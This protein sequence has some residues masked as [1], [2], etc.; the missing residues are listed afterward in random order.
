MAVPFGANVGGTD[1]FLKAQ[2]ALRRALDR[3]GGELLG[4][5]VCAF[6]NSLGLLKEGEPHR[7]T[8]K[9]FWAREPYEQL[10]E[11]LQAA[12]APVV[13]LKEFEDS[14]RAYQERLMR[15]DKLLSPAQISKRNADEAREEAKQVRAMKRALLRMRPDRTRYT[16]QHPKPGH[17]GTDVWG[18]NTPTSPEPPPP[19]LGWADPPPSKRPGRPELQPWEKMPAISDQDKISIVVSSAGKVLAQTAE[20]RQKNLYALQVAR[21]VANNPRLH[22]GDLGI[23]SGMVSLP[24]G[25]PKDELGN[26]D[27][28]TPLSV[29]LQML[30]LFR[31]GKLRATT[32]EERKANR[33]RRREF[34]EMPG[35]R[36]I[37]DARQDSLAVQYGYAPTPPLPNPLPKAPP[38]A[39]AKEK[40][41]TPGSEMAKQVAEAEAR[42]VKNAA[43]RTPADPLL[44]AVEENSARAS[45]ALREAKQA[46]DSVHLAMSQL[47][48]EDSRAARRIRDNELKM[49]SAYEAQQSRRESTGEE[50]TLAEESWAAM[51]MTSEISTL[52]QERRS[53]RMKQQALQPDLDAAISVLLR[54]RQL[55]DINEEHKLLLA[56]INGEQNV[57]VSELRSRYGPAPPRKRLSLPHDAPWQDLA[58][59]SELESMQS[60]EDA[61][62]QEAWL[63][64]VA[65]HQLQVPF[66]EA[67]KPPLR[68][69]EDTRPWVEWVDRRLQVEEEVKDLK[70]QILQRQEQM[71]SDI[72]ELEEELQWLRLL[73][74]ILDAQ[75]RARR[76][77]GR[78]VSTLV[79]G[80]QDKLEDIQ[81]ERRR[82]LASIGTDSAADA[83]AELANLTQ[84]QRKEALQLLREKKR[85]QSMRF[86]ELN[87]E[88][89]GKFDEM[90]PETP[91]EGQELI[92][93]VQSQLRLG[94]TW[95]RFRQ[96]GRGQRQRAAEMAQRLVLRLVEVEHGLSQLEKRTMPPQAGPDP[97]QREARRAAERAEA[98]EA[99]R[100]AA[101]AAGAPVEE[102]PSWQYDEDEIRWEHEEYPDMPQ[103]EV[104]FID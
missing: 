77:V 48:A 11:D 1:D 22:A 87:S 39:K 76:L 52:Q 78:A 89:I 71:S 72:H 65:R 32:P 24:A 104:R 63:R 73:V 102:R 74:R 90:A 51:E 26:P 47:R 15:Q 38:R 68:V 13:T 84:Q 96:V 98:R 67:A 53:L 50:E 75:L 46:F 82:I 44:V 3:A 100:K 30:D 9:T 54:A 16:P 80:I 19:P 97:E 42:A 31:K 8:E 12:G 21:D 66:S 29:H 40:P 10:H 81:I 35:G 2:D 83:A 91:E 56:R 41:E 62:R 27:E 34:E 37:L 99:E 58:T 61:L 14:E 64:R 4:P 93:E 7:D 101:L 94:Q 88:T 85:L 92:A 70:K 49:K 59:A 36:Q 5:L 69:P 28:Y 17:P 60:D 6:E 33:R 55:V 79:R 25:E 23:T 18:D 45:A 95:G 20:Q 103:G 57:D 43:K 86:G